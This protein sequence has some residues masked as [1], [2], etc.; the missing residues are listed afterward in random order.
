MLESWSAPF[1]VSTDKASVGLYTNQF[2]SSYFISGA[3]KQLQPTPTRPALAN[4]PGI[5]PDPRTNYIA[6]PARSTRG[7]GDRAA[8]C[9][10]TRALMIH[11]CTKIVQKGGCTFRS[12]YLLSPHILDFP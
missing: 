1:C 6:P 5:P 2:A 12:P 3:S 10:Y 11:N 9:S 7:S 8:L 4:P